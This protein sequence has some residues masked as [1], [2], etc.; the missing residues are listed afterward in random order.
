MR[1]RGW[2][3]LGI[4]LVGLVSV[5]YGVYQLISIVEATQAVESVA[6]LGELVK[7]TPVAGMFKAENFQPSYLGPVLWIG[8]GLVLMMIGGP[9]GRFLFSGI[10]APV[11]APAAP[12]AGPASQSAGR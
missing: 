7:D 5:L 10:E 9:L 2:V 6:S 11:T 3:T 12:A 1:P 8:A 4:R